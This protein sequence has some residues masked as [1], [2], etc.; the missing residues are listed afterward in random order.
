MDMMDPPMDEMMNAAEDDAMMMMEPMADMEA[1]M[2]PVAPVAA[3]AAPVEPVAAEKVKSEKAKSVES[4]EPPTPKDNLE[5]CCCCLCVC[6]NEYTQESS[7]CGCLPIKAGVISIGVFTLLL[8]VILFMW[9][10]FLFLNEYIHWWYVLVTLLLLAPLIIA[11]AF[12]ISFFTKDT[13]STRT[14]I[15]TAGILTLVSISLTAVWNLIYFIWLYKKDFFYQGMGPIGEN[16]YTKS[17]K[18]SF[19]FTMLGETVI[20]LVLYTYWLCV[21]T[22]YRTVMKGPKT[23]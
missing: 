3:A 8:I 18:K 16:V 23:D 7:C 1:A 19:I 17:N 14:C 12:W 4:E 5:P 15:M 9:N 21:V 6:T 2:A 13:S 11:G 20:L 10:F 22:E